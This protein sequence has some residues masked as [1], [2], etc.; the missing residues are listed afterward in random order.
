MRGFTGSAQIVRRTYQL[1]D[2]LARAILAK[3]QDI[4]AILTYAVAAERTHIAERG[5]SEDRPDS[6]PP[7]ES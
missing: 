3:F 5:V 6:W 7:Q 2:I 1:S 4:L